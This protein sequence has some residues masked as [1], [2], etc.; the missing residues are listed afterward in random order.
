M[1]AITVTIIIL[2]VA[3]VLFVSEVVPVGV[4]S[5]S[6]STALFLTGILNAQ[7]AFS[8]LV[9]SNVILFAGMFVVA[10]A[11][12]ETGLADEIGQNIV[13]AFGKSERKLLAAVMIVSAILSI[14]LSNIAVTASL[15]PVVIS[16]A[17]SAGYARS[18]FL[19][20]L[21][22]ATAL[23]GTISLVGTPP[24]LI[25]HSY[26]EKSGMQGFGFLEFAWYGIP[27]TVVGIIYMLFIGVKLLP[28]RPLTGEELE[29]AAQRVQALKNADKTKQY[30]AAIVFALTVTGM[31][32]NRQIGL[33]LQV[34]A[35]IGALS[36][37]Y[38]KVLTDKQAYRSID[39]NTIFLTGGMMPMAAALDKT[40]A[41]KLISNWVLTAFGDNPSPLFITLAIF[42]VGAVL[43]QFMSNVALAALLGPIA[44]GVAVEMGVNPKAMIL[45]ASFASSCAFVTPVGTPATAIVFGPGKYHFVDFVKAG[46]PLLIISGLLAAVILP[47][48]WPF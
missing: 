23:G 41:G 38:M 45:A 20:P 26:L 6:V 24:N 44:I 37:V 14:F 43:T 21:A 4:T 16:I 48:A 18:K 39:W 5:L 46:A 34:V 2:A 36:L 10:G 19:L 12:F 22:I 27:L 25:V 3:A 13:R 42:T 33:P 40:G 28:E 8:G 1:S 31:F 9:D 35:V 15:M 11:L 32:F 29:K 7:T 17:D 30:I 47:L